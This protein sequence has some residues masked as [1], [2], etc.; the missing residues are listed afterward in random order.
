MATP[1]LQPR[2]PA[3]FCVRA[4]DFFLFCSVFLGSPVGPVGLQEHLGQAAHSSQGETSGEKG[5]L[6]FSSHSSKEKPKVPHL[7]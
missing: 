2:S 6:P 7:P 5:L 4:L 3:F 1:F